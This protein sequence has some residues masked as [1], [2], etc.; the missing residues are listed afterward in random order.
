MDALLDPVDPRSRLAGRRLVRR[1]GS[2]RRWSAFTTALVDGVPPDDGQVRDPRPTLARDAVLLRARAD[3]AERG[4]WRRAAILARLD[5]PHILRLLDVAED[6]SGLPCLLVERLPGGTLAELLRRRQSIAPG[7]AVTILAPLVDA[8]RAAHLAGVGHGAV[9]PGSV[10]FAADGRPVLAGWSDA[11]A[12]EPSQPTA[13][14]EDWIAF[15]ELADGVLRSSSVGERTAIATW[16]AELAP[17]VADHEFANRLQQRIH[18]LARPLPILLD[19]QDESGSS[20]AAV[21]RA[22]ADAPAGG[23]LP[24]TRRAAADDRRRRGSGR[25]RGLRRRLPAGL[26][27]GRS[28][29]RRRLVLGS[30]AGAAALV[31]ATVVLLPTQDEPR[32]PSPAGYTRTSGTTVPGRPAAPE[33]EPITPGSATDPLTA[34]DPV[35]ATGELLA[36]REH[37]RGSHD[38]TTCRLGYVEEGSAFHDAEETGEPLGTIDAAGLELVDRQGDAAVVRGLLDASTTA[39]PTHD[40]RQ[41]VTLLVVRGVTGWRVREVFTAE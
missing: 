6:A 4:L 21:L 16:S 36:R 15:G 19:Q 38:P 7:E 2:G 32:A 25:F 33:P 23:R 41:P 22:S 24:G 35:A 37:C 29:P 8:L 39:G 30:V 11:R 40:A 13:L 14:A 5:H 17:L 12:V 27:D 9:S 18:A 20:V 1:L 10:S 3:A 34:D 28:V 26:T 31:M